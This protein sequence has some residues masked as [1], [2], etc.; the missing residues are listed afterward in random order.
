VYDR[1]SAW[2][3]YSHLPSALCTFRWHLDSTFEAQNLSWWLILALQV[4]ALGLSLSVSFC[5]L[6]YSSFS[7]QGTT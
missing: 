3:R 5:L 4:Y 2:Q 7:G 1:G 6:F